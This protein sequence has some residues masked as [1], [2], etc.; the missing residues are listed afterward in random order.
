MWFTTAWLLGACCGLTL[1]LDIYDGPKPDLSDTPFGY[2]AASTGGTTNESA[3]YVVSTLADLKE[4]AEL[5]YTKTI[6]VNGTIHGNALDDGS[7]ADCQTY[8]DTTGSD[9]SASRQFNFTLYILAFNETYT[10]LVDAA[11]EA[12]ETF[13]GRNAT[14]YS[15]LLS[16][17]N[18]WR[19]TVVAT[20]KSQVGVRLT[21]NTSL[22]GLDT[23]A[24]LDGINLYLSSIDNVWV[25]NLK[26]VSPADC[27]P[28]P[29]TFPSS[30]N[31]EYDAVGLVTST[32]VWVDGCELQD[33]LS[34]EYVVPDEL[35]GWQVDRFDG[36]FDCED[37]T[38]NVTFSHNI[39]RNHHKSL[40]IG[41]GTKEADRDLGKMHFT[42]FGNH[43]D[44]S[45]SRNPLMRFGTFDIA[46]NLYSYANDAEPLYDSTVERRADGPADAVF[47]YH[48]GVYNQS[49]VHVRANAF[50]ATGAYATDASRLFTVSEATLPERPAHVCVDSASTSTLN[51]EAVDMG[52]VAQATVDYFVEE[53]RAVE[54]AVLV[55]CE[56]V[57][58]GGYELPV[59]LAANLTLKIA[60]APPS[61]I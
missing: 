11:A 13:E 5:P 8:I 48:L 54:G 44:S 61:S 55:T 47:Q 27:F 12:G 4:A 6:Y 30:W 43:F 17:Q 28:A 56:G 60:L 35:D 45:A 1:G 50:V 38:D 58:E 57:A 16:H 14:E 10:A 36:L 40:L 37:G 46:S 9:N 59:V 3:V 39:V 15:E 41:G 26:L 51:G 42:I 23:S 53:G 52:T 18:G 29:E 32:N 20:Q 24:A 2:A 21:N 19:P 49:T 7:M 22:V 33:Q 34:G 25:R 31:A